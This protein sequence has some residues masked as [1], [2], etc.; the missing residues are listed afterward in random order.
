MKIFILQQVE[1]IEGDTNLLDPEIMNLYKKATYE[2][3]AVP[4]SRFEEGGTTINFGDNSEMSRQELKFSKQTQ[5]RRKRFSV[6]FDDLLKTQ[7]ISKK[8][9]TLDEWQPIKQKIVYVWKNDSYFVMQKKLDIL[10][11]QMDSAAEMEPYVGKYF[12]HAYVRKQIFQQ[13]DEDIE[14]MDKEILE[15]TKDKRYEAPSEEE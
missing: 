4:F 13:T 9:I 10:A 11:R 8:I 3:L 14:L 6:M 1:T 2:S 5:K 15:E 12:S 7:L